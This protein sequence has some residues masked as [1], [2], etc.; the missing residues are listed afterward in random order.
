[1]LHKQ[2]HWHNNN[3]SPTGQLTHHALAHC[4]STNGQQ[5]FC[6]FSKVLGI[7]KTIWREIELNLQ[8]GVLT[9][10]YMLYSKLTSDQRLDVFKFQSDSSVFV[11][12]AVLK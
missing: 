3:R 12:A 6:I 8:S 4:A 1:M 9:I 2:I 7:A 10:T 11:I 5:M